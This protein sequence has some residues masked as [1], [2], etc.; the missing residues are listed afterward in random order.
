MQTG[1][2]HIYEFGAFQLDPAKRL[3][4]RLDGTPV[5]LTP[6]V[7]E[8]LLYMLEHH[9]SVLDKE[10]IME[11][12][13]PDSIVEENNLAQAISKLRQ[14]FG[15]TPGSHGYI[16]TVPGR[17]YRFVAEVME[18]TADA[19]AGASVELATTEGLINKSTP[20]V[21]EDVAVKRRPLPVKRSL[22]RCYCLRRLALQL[23][24]LFTTAVCPAV[25]GC[26][27]HLSRLA[28]C[29]LPR[30]AFPRRAS[31]CCRLIILAM[32]SKTPFS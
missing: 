10:R 16:V 17:G 3:L 21:L 1:S 11:A 19:G 28:R 25:S 23:W 2:G 20:R 24:F 13:W 15:E 4:R 30:R 22:L 27:T 6:R 26:Q 31:P 7:F 5:P 29:Y 32:I 8:T 9:E 12:V 18:K 14:V